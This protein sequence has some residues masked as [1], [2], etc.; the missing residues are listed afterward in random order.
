MANITELV[1][2][3]PPTNAPRHVHIQLGSM[4]SKQATNLTTRALHQSPVVK[5]CTAL[6]TNAQ[7]LSASLEIIP[8][9]PLKNCTILFGCALH[10]SSTIPENATDLMSFGSYQH[11]ISGENG[12]LPR[13]LTYPLKFDEFF[14][15]PLIKPAPLQ[16]QQAAISFTSNFV[17][18]DEDS[19]I[20]DG[21]NIFHVFVRGVIS[22]GGTAS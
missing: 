15:S 18:H 2:H 7:W 6:F 4:T 9:V 3:A 10:G 19:V 12:S 1:N 8:L 11:F 13:I 16:M 21:D 5:H 20:A 17:N 22:A 14:I